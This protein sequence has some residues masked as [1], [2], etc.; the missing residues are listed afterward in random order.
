[1]ATTD[2]DGPL[3]ATGQLTALLSPPQGS[4]VQDPNPDAGPSGFAF[5]TAVL[6]ARFAVEKDRLNGYVGR[7]PAMLLSSRIASTIGTPATLASNNI[8]A[9]QGVTSGVAMTL[10]AANATGVSINVPFFQPG[11]YG[12]TYASSGVVLAPVALDFGFSFGNVTAGNAV[13]PVGGDIR[14]FIPGM[15]LVIVGAGANGG[16]LLTTVA[17]TTLTPSVGITAGSI[18]VN[19]NAL[20]QTSVDPA[21]IGTGNIWPAV[22]SGQPIQGLPTAAWPGLASGVG[23]YSVG[24]QNV[25]SGPLLCFDP[26]QG[27]QRGIRIVGASGSAGGTF[28]VTGADIFGYPVTDLVTVAGGAS[29]GYTLKTFK[30]VLSVVP[31]FTDAGHN[32]TVGTVDLFGFA[33]RCDDFSDAS[34]VWANA[35]MTSATGY[36]APDI[37]DPATDATG[38]PRGT[39][40]LTSAGPGSGIG[41]TASNGTVSALAWTGNKLY[42]HAHLSPAAL[43]RASPPFAES[44]F[45]TPPQ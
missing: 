29:T 33:V 5:G 22:S 27:I 41:A 4:P 11:G 21:P 36:T 43:L 25:A 45:G 17:S 26:S 2:V 7:A 34:V 28:L 37:T 13:I 32:Y 40:Q 20:P 18:T 31:Q 35:L 12:G 42:M 15:P 3:L 14:R 44:M 24:S 6:D 10:A 38:D 39:I 23:G 30:Y 8:A 16:C 9:A 19:P 1:M